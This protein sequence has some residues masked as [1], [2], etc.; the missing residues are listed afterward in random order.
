MRSTT[1]FLYYVAPIIHGPRKS[2][3]VVGSGNRIR[4]LGLV[5]GTPLRITG[6]H[7]RQNVRLRLSAGV[8]AQRIKDGI[9]YGDV[10]ARLVIP[11]L[12]NRSC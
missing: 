6:F 1:G 8:L 3:I 11:W 7:G 4:E 9:A 2:R 12:S 10:A 5:S